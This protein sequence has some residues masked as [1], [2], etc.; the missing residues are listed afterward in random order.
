MTSYGTKEVHRDGRVPEII[1]SSTLKVCVPDAQLP[2]TASLGAG[3]PAP[4]PFSLYI[5]CIHAAA[6]GFKLVAPG[7]GWGRRHI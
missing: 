5:Q 4:L 3:F 7:W 1:A 6:G 2:R